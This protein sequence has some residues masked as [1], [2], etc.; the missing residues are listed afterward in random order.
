[1]IMRLIAC[2]LTCLAMPKLSVATELAPGEGHSV[3]L[4]RFDADVYYTV[5]KD[6][7]RVV[8]T[9]A[10]AAEALPIRFVSTLGPGQR[11]V[12]SV[13]RSVNQLRD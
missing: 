1:M 11:L 5:E 10:S 6:G 4:E 13:P 9:L 8:A 7:L 12:I 2:A 3:H